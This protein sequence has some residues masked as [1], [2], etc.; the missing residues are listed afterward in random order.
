MQQDRYTCGMHLMDLKNSPIDAC[1]MCTCKAIYTNPLY[2]QQNHFSVGLYSMGVLQTW[3]CSNL[4]SRW[5]I[6]LEMN[7][8]D[9]W[10]NDGVENTNSVTWEVIR[11]KHTKWALCLVELIL[12]Q[13]IL[14]QGLEGQH[15]IKLS[16]AKNLLTAA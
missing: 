9:E 4:N 1:H 7:S 13:L 11:R 3:T 8:S 10:I 15:I 16:F 12:G 5:Y 6:W 2:S 14:N